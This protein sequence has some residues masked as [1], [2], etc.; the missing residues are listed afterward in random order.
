MG[1]MTLAIDQSDVWFEVSYSLK[2]SYHMAVARLL[3]YK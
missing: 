3:W 2:T 1:F